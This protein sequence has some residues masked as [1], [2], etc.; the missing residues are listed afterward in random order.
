[1]VPR[2]RANINTAGKGVAAS[3]LVQFQKR[4]MFQKVSQSA[5][6][7]R[8]EIGIANSN[9]ARLALPTHREIYLRLTSCF[10]EKEEI[11]VSGRRGRSPAEALS[12]PKYPKP[13]LNLCV[14]SPR[15]ECFV[16]VPESAPAEISFTPLLI[17]G[18]RVGP[19]SVS[20][21]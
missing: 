6:P 15:F 20:T 4:N 3:R 13:R 11:W 18:L 8:F 5:R 14:P 9:I 19:R 2:V 17:R 16:L 1:M 7:G 10:W 21:G 12:L